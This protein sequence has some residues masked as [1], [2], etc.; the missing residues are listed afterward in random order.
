M[1]VC[2]RYLAQ[3]WV[4]VGGDFREICHPGCSDNATAHFQ[5]LD[6]TC[7]ELMSP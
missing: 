5:A 1:I 3:R 7:T 4:G 6:P 2:T